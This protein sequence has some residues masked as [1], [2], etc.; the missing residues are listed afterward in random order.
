MKNMRSLLLT[1]VA[2]FGL[3]AT[4]CINDDFTDSPAERL[5]FS[6]DTVA[7]DTVFTGVGTPTAR[8]VVR[9]PNKKGVTISRIAFRNPDSRFSLNVDGMSGSTFSDVEIRGR[10]SIYIFIECFIPESQGA[11]P[12][13]TADQLD[14]TLANA[15]QTV[16]VEAWGQNV[17]RLRGLRLEH[18]MTLTPEMPYVV[19]D[20]LSVEPGAT[21]RILPG[22]KLLFHDKALLAV[23][24]RLEAVGEPGR[25]I[26][27]R[28]DRLDNV[29]PDVGYDILAGQWRGIRFAPESFDNRLEYVD[30]RSTV[31]GVTVDSCG[32]LDRRK[33]LIVNS[34]LH[35]SQATALDSRHAW[36][37]A[38][39]VCFSDAAEAVVRLTGGRH[40][41]SQCTIAN[42]YLFAISPEPMLSLYHCLPEE[43]DGSAAPLMKA[44]F[45]NGIIYG[46]TS[47][48]NVKTLEGTDVFMRNILF[49]ETGS[50]D[51]HFISCLWDSDPL[52]LTVRD[53]Y[54]FNYRLKA[55]SPAIGAGNP[56]YVSE[57]TV[58]DI[59][60]VDR[61]AG[62]NPTLGAYA[63]I[64]PSDTVTGAGMPRATVSWKQM[65]VTNDATPRITPAASSA[66]A[67]RG[68]RRSST[69]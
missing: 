43:A 47:S 19:F 2:L 16:E 69:L 68:D 50:D 64:E 49:K 18:D 12:S 59:D 31:A 26:D 27:M 62:G 24:G 63:Y 51:D 22:V 7:F 38:A 65:P 3:I 39:G 36:V 32:T 37:D 53:D 66:V 6:T 42:Y 35:N 67:S 15:S 10:D 41:F 40:D 8:L 54:Y 45:A 44:S 1:F 28:G 23:R 9:N 4:S 46:M 58:F 14:F 33:L 34:W 17:R 29:L 55:G 52:F 61:L 13:L 5:I 57:L 30:M 21:L 25:L 56:A 20:S 11:E 48:I 60:G